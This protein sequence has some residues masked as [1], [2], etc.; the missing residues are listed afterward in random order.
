MN[1]YCTQIE[2]CNIIRKLNGHIITN[3]ILI[4]K[5]IHIFKRNDGIKVSIDGDRET[6]DRIRGKGSYDKAIEA[7]ENLREDGIRHSI[8]FMVCRKN[9]YCI[10]HIIELRRGIRNE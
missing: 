2:A 7:L 6:H 3:G 5:F 8:G 10:D 1:L 4:L 9:F